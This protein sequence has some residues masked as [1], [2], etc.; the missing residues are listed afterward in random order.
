MQNYH[1]ATFLTEARKALDHRPVSGRSTAKARTALGLACAIGFALI[2]PQSY[3][4]QQVA[5]AAGPFGGLAGSWSGGGVI[6]MRD[7]GQERIRCRGVYDVQSG[8]NN[9]R[10]Q[11][12]CASDSYKFE[13]ST[14]ITEMG[15]QLLGNWS[16]NTRH[17][18]GRISGH[19]TATSIRARAEGDLFTAMLSVST[20]G[21]R[22]SV[23]ITSPGAE[24][25]EVSIAL[26]R[27]R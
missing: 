21:D 9:I 19:A 8:G 4:Q 23:S 12:R 3:A 18:A 13:M 5:T 11:L 24:I 25:S 17:V 15:G 22:Q 27:G 2:A 16:E 20:H 1:R 7:G 14:D 6:K 26:T 10:Q